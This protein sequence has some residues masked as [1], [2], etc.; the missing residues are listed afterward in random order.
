LLSGAAGTFSRLTPRR[1][2]HQRVGLRQCVPLHCLAAVKSALFPPTSVVMGRAAA[3]LPL[4][5]GL[6]KNSWAC[7]RGLSV[8]LPYDVRQRSP[9]VKLQALPNFS[10]SFFLLNLIVLWTF[11]SHGNQ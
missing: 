2:S 11:F 4:K 7:V 9:A 10:V 8:L 1:R 5:A 6:R 3:Q